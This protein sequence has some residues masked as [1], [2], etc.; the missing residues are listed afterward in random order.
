MTTLFRV[1]IGTAVYVLILILAAPFPSAAGLML[2]FPTLNGLG[3]V[4]CERGRVLAM[5]PSMLWMPVV[6]GALCA[7]YLLAF[8]ALARFVPSALLAWGLLALAIV[9]FGVI[10]SQRRVQEG[11]AP[12]RQLAFAMAATLIGIV[13][14]AMA[15]F[16]TEMHTPTN[17]AGDARDALAQLL[18][19]RL[20]TGATIR[21][22]A[23][24]ALFVICLAAFLMVPRILPLSDQQRGIL[25]GLPVVPLGGL[26]S[27]AGDTGIDLSTR[28]DIVRHMAASIWLGPAIAI[29]F[30]YAF[31][32][33]LVRLR[34]GG[35][36]AFAALAVGWAVCG[37][38]VAA[39]TY[40]L[41][42]FGVG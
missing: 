39:A 14:A 38:A 41:S 37:L 16:L 18:S 26:L 19:L 27:I 42:Q 17:T 24:I 30:V 1:L 13:L 12:S 9:L 34:P 23:K 25:A 21:N 15:A 10:V 8:L 29:W 2:V 11:I 20:A 33:A 22:G 40:A 36:R 28:L 35:V 32:R 7:G 6:N 5:A 3:Y 4:L 31:P